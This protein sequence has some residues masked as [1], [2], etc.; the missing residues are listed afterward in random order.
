MLG[1]SE[2]ES[3]LVGRSAVRCVT[4]ADPNAWIA[5]DFVDKWIVPTH[6]TIRHYTTWDTECVRSWRL[7]VWGSHRG[8]IIRCV[9][10]RIIQLRDVLTLC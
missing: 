5:V 4:K 6:Y 10:Y 7:E 3:Y 8:S 9:L 1:D 2:D